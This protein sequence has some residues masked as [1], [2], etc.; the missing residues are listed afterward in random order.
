MQRFRFYHLLFLLLLVFC[1][2]G[3]KERGN[4]LRIAIDPMWYS[5]NMPDRNREFNGFA[6]DFLQ[7]V[8]VHQK[9]KIAKVKENWDNMLMR[10]Q[11]KECEGILYSMQPYLFYEKQYDF[12]EPFLLTG[13]VLVLPE[14]SKLKSLKELS[15]KEVAVIEG[16]GSEIVIEKYPGII[17]RQFASIPDAFQALLAQSV[18]AAVVDVLHA[19]AYCQDLYQGKLKVVGEPLTN[20]GLRLVTLHGS[21]PQLIAAF[22]ST[23]AELQKSHQYDTLLRKWRLK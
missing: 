4:E 23:L 3:K 12:S 14:A 20:E 10:L 17:I 9:M 7:E 5:V 19:S 21:A 16:A 1:N 18:D 8:S 13:P 2:C 15:G 22:N 11:K 6:N